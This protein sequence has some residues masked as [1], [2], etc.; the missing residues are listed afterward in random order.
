MIYIL[1]DI[2]INNFT[3]YISFFFIVYLYNKTYKYYLYIALILDFIIFETYFY[4]I[5]ILTIIYTFNKIFKD[6]N[7]NN[8]LVF[9]F[10]NMFNYLLYIILSNI[11]VF[12]NVDNI[13]LSIGSNLFINTIFYILSYRLVKE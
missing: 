12:N 7:K 6:L 9:F 4:N 2:L 3:N 13:L 5:I 10:I 8:F 11:I 1:L